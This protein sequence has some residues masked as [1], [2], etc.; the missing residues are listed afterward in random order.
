METVF[1]KDVFP[2]PFNIL[3]SVS[4][5]D[6]FK[7]NSKIERCIISN[8]F[9]EIEHNKF[10]VIFQC[11]KCVNN[12]V[13]LCLKGKSM[14]YEGDKDF[15]IFP[16]KFKWL[17]DPLIYYIDV[18]VSKSIKFDASETH[19]PDKCS[20]INLDLSSAKSLFAISKRNVSLNPEHPGS[21]EL[22]G[23]LHLPFRI[24]SCYQDT[25]GNSSTE[26]LYWSTSE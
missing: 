14:K 3:E 10:T 23:L 26:L 2:I 5:F 9:I 16:V 20:A 13:F 7:G 22:C 15:V 18:I 24:C 4:A 17:I 8:K 11:I 12:D 19:Q 1:G 6:N 25:I 21:M